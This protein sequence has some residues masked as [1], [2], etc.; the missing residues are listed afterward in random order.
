MPSGTRKYYDWHSA[1]DT[2]TL[3]TGISCYGLVGFTCNQKQT[4][5]IFMFSSSEYMK[6][7][8]HIK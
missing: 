1:E 6:T 2:L 7:G 4:N 5:I 8:R 3:A